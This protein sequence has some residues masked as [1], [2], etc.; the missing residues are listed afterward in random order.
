LDLGLDLAFADLDPCCDPC[1]DPCLLLLSGSGDAD[2]DLDVCDPTGDPAGDPVEL[3][4]SCER[5]CRY[6]RP[7]DALRRAD[8]DR[9]GDARDGGGESTAE[10]AAE[11]AAEST[12]TSL[13]AHEL[14]IRAL[15]G[16]RPGRSSFSRARSPSSN[17]CSCS[18]YGV[19]GVD[20][21]SP[22]PRTCA[23]TSPST[24]TPRESSLPSSDSSAS[25]SARIR[26]VVARLERERV[27]SASRLASRS[28]ALRASWD[29]CRSAE[30]CL[31]VEAV[32]SE[33][34]DSTAAVRM[35]GA[36]LAGERSKPGATGERRPAGDRAG[37]RPVGV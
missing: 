7:G 16:R 37:D 1:C 15:G 35:F 24:L 28:A 12:S 26:D 14:S 18:L 22:R 5:W 32:S 21:G 20:S 27:L 31:E 34:R 33:V 2:A 8:L 25:R 3:P 30:R 10:P 9:R 4:F 19:D 6:L 13:A 17:D 23:S 29:S 36:S 11:P